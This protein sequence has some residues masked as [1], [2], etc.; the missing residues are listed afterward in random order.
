MPL[1]DINAMQYSIVYYSNCIKEERERRNE[2]FLVVIGDEEGDE[3]ALELE[4]QK[5]AHLLK[6]KQDKEPRLMD[7]IRMFKEHRIDYRKFHDKPTDRTG[8]FPEAQPTEREKL[9]TKEDYEK[10]AKDHA[11]QEGLIGPEE[12]NETA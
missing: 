3:D 8:L 4:L 1:A 5:M 12:K 9:K 11:E 6:R 10:Y 7:R 2:R